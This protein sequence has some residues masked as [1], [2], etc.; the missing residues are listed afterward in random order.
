[1]T[2][3]ANEC[4]ALRAIVK[5]EYQ[6]DSSDVV[7]VPVWTRYCNPFSS[8]STF[9]GVVSSLVQKGFVTVDDYSPTE[10]TIA[11][12]QSGFDALNETERKEAIRIECER[13]VPY[14]C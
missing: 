6:N 13:P 1:M 8:K 2:L 5:S 7:D 12:T 9:S 4:K 11:I 10:G 3:T 14:G